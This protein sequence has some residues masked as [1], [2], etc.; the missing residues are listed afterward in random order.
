VRDSSCVDRWLF[1]DGM[2]EALAL[3]V[4]ATRF[5]CHRDGPNRASSYAAFSLLHELF[6]E[7]EAA[8]HTR[9]WYD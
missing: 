9:Y 8:K 2:A 6:P 5:G 4:R 3:S 1:G 7:S